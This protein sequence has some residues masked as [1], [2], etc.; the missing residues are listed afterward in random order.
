MRTSR[1]WLLTMVLTAPAFALA[2]V[3]L[4]YPVN[5]LVTGVGVTSKGGWI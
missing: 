4:H 2:S 3:L 5:C 1:P